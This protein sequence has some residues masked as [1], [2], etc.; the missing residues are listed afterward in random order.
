[1]V[2]Q[3]E[4]EKALPPRFRNNFSINA[5]GCFIWLKGKSS[6]G[7]GAF[8]WEGK[9]WRAHR[10]AWERLVDTIP[11]GMVLDH[12]RINPGEREAPCSK[13]C[14]NPAHLEVV[15]VGENLRRRKH[16]NSRKTHCTSCG[17][18][19]SGSNVYIVPSTGGRECVSCRKR[20]SKEEYARRKVSS[21]ESQ[22]G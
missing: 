9:Q 22:Q 4:L 18:P 12:Y 20:Y 2:L 7:Y 19:Y 17:L 6:D 13:V 21:R 11:L 3:E 1:M 10:F 16:Y 5:D 15:T 8:W 14:V